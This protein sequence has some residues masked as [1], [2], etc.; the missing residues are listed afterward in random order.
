M[1]K[2]ETVRQIGVDC[3]RKFSTVSARDG[4]GRI[5]WRDRLEHEDRRPLRRRLRTWP[6]GTPIVLEATFGWGWLADE[7]LAAGLEPHLA[8][9]R[10]VAAWRHLLLSSIQTNCATFPGKVEQQ[11]G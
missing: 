5:M 6:E 2:D 1:N 8:S 9:S 7:L 11:M 3:H 4:M 10:K